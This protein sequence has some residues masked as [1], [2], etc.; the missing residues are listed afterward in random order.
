MERENSTGQA[1]G[2][3]SFIEAVIVAWSMKTPRGKP[4]ASTLEQGS[5]RLSFIIRRFIVH[6]HDIPANPEHS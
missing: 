2:I 1:R 5:I 4:V 3:F 6:I